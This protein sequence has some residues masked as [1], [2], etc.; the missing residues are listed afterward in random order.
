MK[1]SFFHHKDIK[2]EIVL[3]YEYSEDASESTSWVKDI[4]YSM[5]KKGSLQKVG[6]CD[7]RL[8]MNDEIYYAGQVG[9]RVYLPFRGHGYA[10]D[11][12]KL[13][14][15]IAKNEYHMNDLIITCSPENIASHK[16]LEKLKGTLIEKI[17]VPESHWL[18]LRGETVKCIY[19][20]VL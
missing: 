18:Y 4:H 19:R 3:R 6:E 10:Y 15:E 20:F 14:F 16:T 8:G 12:C 7:L 11:A 1:F 13:L 17:D 5:C 9:Y 2:E